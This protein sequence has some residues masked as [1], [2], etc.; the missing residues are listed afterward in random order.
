[1][2]EMPEFW[3]IMDDGTKHRYFPDIFVKSQNR[4]IEVKSTYTYR[5]GPPNVIMAKAK[6]VVDA[7][8]KINVYILDGKKQIVETI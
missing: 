8:Y 5:L 1:M 6:C 4:F 3:Y 2:K 7:G